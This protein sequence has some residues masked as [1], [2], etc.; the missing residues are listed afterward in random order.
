MRNLLALLFLVPVAGFL[1]SW[2]GAED[3]SKNWRRLGV[4]ILTTLT[5]I[6]MGV[7]NIFILA[8]HFGVLWGSLTLGYGESSPLA[9]FWTWVL[10]FWGF[11]EWN[12]VNFFIRTT[13]GICYGAGCAILLLAKG[14]PVFLAFLII[15]I[16]I[17]TIN[18]VIW[19]CFIDEPPGIVV[20]GKLLTWEELLVGAGVGLAA[21]ICM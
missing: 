19:A 13:V 4:P 2:G 10:A 5:A 9:T 20:F 8:A 1:W 16:A 11:P 15:P 3:T 12:K 18:T 21:G 14:F 17:T 7:H 6:L